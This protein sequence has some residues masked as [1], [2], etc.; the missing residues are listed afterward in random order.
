MLLGD[1]LLLPL[2]HIGKSRRKLFEHLLLLDFDVLSHLRFNLISLRIVFLIFSR[3]PRGLGAVIHACDR[4][5]QH[6]HVSLLWLLEMVQRADTS[7]WNRP[8]TF[9]HLLRNFFSEIKN[10]N[11]EE[12]I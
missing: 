3:G 6:G 1:R 5:R 10:Y 11:S 4:K 7:V 9:V 12:L 8:L 2:K